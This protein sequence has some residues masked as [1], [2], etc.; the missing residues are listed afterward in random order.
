[1]ARNVRDT[2]TGKTLEIGNTI[3]GAKRDLYMNAGNTSAAKIDQGV[4]MVNSMIPTPL[5]VIAT[6][7]RSPM[8]QTLHRKQSWQYNS[9][10][11]ETYRSESSY[12]TT[13]L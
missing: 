3:A 13:R 11:S 2:N 8:L 5:P 1:M 7:L 4:S 6:D 9:K 12:S 10:L